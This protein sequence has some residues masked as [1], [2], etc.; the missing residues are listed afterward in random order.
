MK[1]EGAVIAMISEYP[2]NNRSVCVTVYGYVNL[3]L[4]S[5]TRI[6]HY[7]DATYIIAFDRKRKTEWC[8]SIDK[9][10]LF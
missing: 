9:D 6:L 3:A 1:I 7:F 2:F 8:K 5:C 4:C 10:N